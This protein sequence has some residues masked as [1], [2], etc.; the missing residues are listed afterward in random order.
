MNEPLKIKGVVVNA[1]QWGDNDKMLTVLTREKGVISIAA[2]GVK[3]LK[4]KNSQA[5]SPLCY[6]DFVLNDKGDAYSLVSAD[7]IESFYALR[8]DVMALAYGVYFAQLAAFSVGRNN[9]ADDE[10][11]LLLNS[12]YMLTKS[13]ERME[14]IKCAF[15]LKLCEYA[16]FAP[17][18]DSCMCGE[19]GVYFDVSTG[20]MVCALH[21]GEHSKKISPAARSVFEYVQNADLKETLTF[22]IDNSV[23]EEVSLLAE[24]FLKHQLGRLPKGLDYIKKLKI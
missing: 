14:V 6:S 2:K 5:V 10:M 9:L 3:S 11:R 15:E 19:E 18:L 21:R 7:L 20:E 22:T 24:E 12:L 17:Y 4:N 23:A 13:K 8:E 1:A 16:G